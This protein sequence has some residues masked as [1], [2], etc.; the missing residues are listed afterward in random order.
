MAGTLS[1]PAGTGPFTAVVLITGSGPPDRDETIVGHKP[2]LVIADY[3]ARRDIAVLRCDD[4]GTAESTG[5]FPKATSADFATDVLAAMR[6]LATV[7]GIDPGRIGLIGHSEG[8]L[9]APMVA[10]LTEDVDFSRVDLLHGKG[11]A[12]GSACLL[13]A[14]MTATEIVKLL[15]ARAPTPAAPYGFV[16]DPTQR[17]TVPLQRV[18]SLRD[19][20]EGRGICESFF[21]RIP[22]LRFLHERELGLRGASREELS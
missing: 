22:E 5:S 1:M 8:G 10:G 9:I 18:P 20:E 17:R 4:R 3:L 16:F 7:D 19:S 13:A 12:V 11:P 6:F 21:R 14:A 15:G 2:F